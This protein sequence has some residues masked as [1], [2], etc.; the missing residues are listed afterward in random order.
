VNKVVPTAELEALLINW[1]KST[2]NGT[3]RECI[4]HFNPYLISKEKKDEFS[5]MVKRMAILKD[6]VLALRPGLG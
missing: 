5:G 2:P 3:T 6:G 4:Q 1:L